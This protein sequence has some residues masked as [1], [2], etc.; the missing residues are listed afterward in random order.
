MAVQLEDLREIEGGLVGALEENEP[1]QVGETYLAQV[2]ILAVQKENL[3]VFLEEEGQIWGEEG[4]L[5]GR[6]GGISG[7]D[8][9]E[10]GGM[11]LDTTRGKRSSTRA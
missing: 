9:G 10:V 1:V 2:E 8:C 11:N 6:E 7:G 4:E 3:E 5:D